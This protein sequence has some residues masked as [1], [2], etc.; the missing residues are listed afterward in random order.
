M[1]KE[2]IEV[3][4]DKLI[5]REKMAMVEAKR[6]KKVSRAAGQSFLV[7][8]GLSVVLLG[9]GFISTGVAS[10]LSHLPVIGS[11]YKDFG[12]MASDKIE[13]DQLMTEIEKQ[14]HQNGL[15]MT[16][17]EAAYD[18]GRLLVTVAYTGDREVSLAEEVVGTSYLTVNGQP[19]EV[20]NNSTGQDDFDAKTIIEHHQITLA[21]YDAYGDEIE[22]VVHGEDLFGYAGEWEVAFPLEKI[23]DD[24]SV[25][26]SGVTA[27]TTDGIY[28]ITADQ[29]T[30]TP[31][32]T[33]IDLSIDYPVEMD[34]NDAWPWFDFHVVDEK[35]NVYK[36][37]ELASG[38][39][40][41]NTRHIV[42]TLPPMDE[43]PES[44]TLKPA[45]ISNEGGFREEIKELELVVPLIE[46]N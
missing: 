39:A 25:F 9:S 3:P 34:A 6:K 4:V 35:G 43:I 29:V 14:D 19:I 26:E 16:V 30:F 12:D 13:Q 32:S 11:I 22:V 7:A 10:A 24:T 36:G 5:V 15:T 21:E 28:A 8:C 2:K 1:N 20:A 45:D 17:K 18:G 44:F 31:L 33:R 46:K 23:G 42:L 27:K 38:V 41:E 37:L 40:G